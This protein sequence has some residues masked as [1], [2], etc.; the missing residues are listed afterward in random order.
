MSFGQSGGQSSGQ[1]VPQ[2]GPA[3]AAEAAQPLVS[4]AQD[5]RWAR[6]QHCMVAGELTHVNFQGPVACLVRDTSSTGA[7]VEL[8]GAR[9]AFTAGTERVP[10]HITLVMPVDRVS[11]ECRVTWRKGTMLGLRYLAP[12]RMIAK[13]AMP[14]RPQIKARDKGI[15]GGL[16]K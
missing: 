14:Q 9:N 1:S 16:F 3:N 4:T 12:V 15:L 7:R 13:R 8:V 2:S 5:G 11:V 6:R 10:D